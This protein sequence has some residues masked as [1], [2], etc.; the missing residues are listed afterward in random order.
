[1]K[2]DYFTNR[3]NKMNL[4][5]MFLNEREIIT[6]SITDA[7][8]HRITRVNGYVER[9]PVSKRIDKL[10]IAWWNKTNFNRLYY[11]GQ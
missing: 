2:N 10:G 1:M 11:I 4:D 3:R 8:P 7:F 6:L 5:K 9:R